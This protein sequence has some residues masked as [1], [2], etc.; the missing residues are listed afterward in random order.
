MARNLALL[1]TVSKYSVTCHIDTS[2]RCKA[3][4][5]PQGNKTVACTHEKRVMCY[6]RHQ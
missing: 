5:K 1:S 6:L 3:Q 4:V 2:V